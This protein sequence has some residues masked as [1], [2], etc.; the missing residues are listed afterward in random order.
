VDELAVGDAVQSGSSANALNPQTAILALLDAAIPLRIAI[1][2]IGCFL[3]GLVEL[4]LGEEEALGPLEILLAPSPALCAAFYACHGFSP[5]CFCRPGNQMRILA[6]EARKPQ[7]GR[8]EL[9]IF[10]E[11]KRVAKKRGKALRAM[12][13]FP[14]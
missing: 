8:P 5:Y 6:A 9:Q 1:R 11:A 10:S 7:A 14:V 13:L 3:S 4:A 12:G 2:A